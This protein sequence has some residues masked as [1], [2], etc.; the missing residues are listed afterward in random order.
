[1]SW[2]C[3]VIHWSWG[4]FKAPVRWN[5]TPGS[6]TRLL[7]DLRSLLTVDW[8]YQILVMCASAGA[9]KH[10]SLLPLEW[11]IERNRVRER[12]GNHFFF[13]NLISEVISL[14][15]FHILFLRIKS[16]S[17]ASLLEEITQDVDTKRWD[18]WGHFRDCL[19]QMSWRKFVKL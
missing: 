17:L 5:Q 18:H 12:D 19:P 11:R 6:L 4:H 2:G 9:L 7:A 13:G 3:N 8:R 14:Y 16:L 1:M 10:G 15:F